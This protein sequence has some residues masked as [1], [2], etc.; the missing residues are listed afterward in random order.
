M[1]RGH[2]LG[3]GLMGEV[4]ETGRGAENLDTGDRVVVPSPIACCHC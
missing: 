4:V 2:I 3:R 1:K